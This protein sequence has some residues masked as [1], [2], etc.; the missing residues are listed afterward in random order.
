[1]TRKRMGPTA[2]PWPWRASACRSG[3]LLASCQVLH[4][5]TLVAVRVAALI[6]L[7]MISC[8]CWR[9]LSDGVV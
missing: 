8:L 9:N 7:V 6:D 4:L 2:R 5:L 1:M 3:G